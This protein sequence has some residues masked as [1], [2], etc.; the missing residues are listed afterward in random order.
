MCGLGRPFRCLAAVR[1]HKQNVLDLLVLEALFLLIR[2][3]QLE[4]PF[5]NGGLAHPFGQRSEL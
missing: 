3:R 1:D 4:R 5:A 2:A